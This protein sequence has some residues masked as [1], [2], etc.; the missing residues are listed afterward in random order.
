ML[1]TGPMQEADVV[2]AKGTFLKAKSYFFYLLSKWWLILV[3]C[4]AGALIG[5]YRAYNTRPTYTATLNFVLSTGTKNSNIS[6]IASQLGIDV[7]GP[8]NNDVFSGDNILVLFKSKKMI[9]EVLFKKP[10]Q[11][12]ESLVNIIT[13]E[14]KLDKQWL[15]NP[16]TKNLFPFPD[17]M[18]LT[19]VQDSLF[20]EVYNIIVKKQ[21]NVR[22]TDSKLSIYT[23][24]TVSTNEVFAC[25][26]T[27]YLMDETADFYINTKTSTAKQTLQLLQKEADSLKGALNGS[28]VHVAA[29]ADRTFALNPAMQVQRAPAQTSQVRSGVLAATYAEIVKNLELAKINLQRE[30]P[31]YQIIDSPEMPLVMKKSN[32]RTALMIGGFIGG[33]IIIMLLVLY[34]VGKS[35]NS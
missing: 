10:P 20:R 30:N 29:E 3:F 19:P 27:R 18:Q 24:S 12:A 4:A 16:R 7:A 17:S 21:L 9:K 32:K 11:S 33:F 14:L 28:I 26:L 6:G 31:L 25:Y 5:L 15:K 35:L 23:V 1:T 34:R 13:R 2:T 8:Q 22:R